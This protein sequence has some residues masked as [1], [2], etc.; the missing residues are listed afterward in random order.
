MYLIAGLILITT[1]VFFFREYR[2][3]NAK[4]YAAKGAGIALIV[5]MLLVLKH[6]MGESKWW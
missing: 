6:W 2:K 4:V 5:G 1:S 3:P